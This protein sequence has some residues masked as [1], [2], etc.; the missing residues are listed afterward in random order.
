MGTQQFCL[1]WNNHQGNLVSVF[2]DLLCHESFVDVTLACEGQNIKAHKLVL[3]ACSP[4]F[5]DVFKSNPCKHP[6]VILKDMK[7]VDLKT[8]VTFMYK[9]EVSIS[10]VMY[11]VLIYL[12]FLL[13]FIN[14][15]IFL[16]ELG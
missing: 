6:V 2:G 9:G 12:C 11:Q 16:F 15:Y 10:Q 1:K 13:Y 8:I 3:S 7:Y 14:S 4:F 5:E